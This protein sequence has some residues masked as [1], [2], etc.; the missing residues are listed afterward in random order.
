MVI[1]AMLKPKFIPN[2]LL[3]EG[4]ISP[5]KNERKQN[6]KT[7]KSKTAQGRTPH[8]RAP[9]HGHRVEA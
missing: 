3:K 1:E 9:T 2:V 6:I 7:E 8:G 5:P 4:F